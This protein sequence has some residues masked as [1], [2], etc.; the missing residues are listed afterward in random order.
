MLAKYVT[1]G[2]KKAPLK[3][4]R[5]LWSYYG[6]ILW[7]FHVSHVLRNERSV[8]SLNRPE[9]F[10]CEGRG[11]RIYCCGLMLSSETPILKKF[12]SVC[13]ALNTRFVVLFVFVVCKPM[14]SAIPGFERQAP[15]W[16]TTHIDQGRRP[17]ERRTCFFTFLSL[18]IDSC[19]VQLWFETALNNYPI[20]IPIMWIFLLKWRP[21][22][23]KPFSSLGKLPIVIS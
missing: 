18:F 15:D 14:V 10:S 1:I 13:W 4:I 6:C 3:K 2:P 17:V 22:F 21:G 9:R 5:S 23:R 7:L 12:T 19:C 8:L 20:V 16:Q 11:L